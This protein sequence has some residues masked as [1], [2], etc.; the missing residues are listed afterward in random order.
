[1]DGRKEMLGIWLS[2]NESAS[3][4]TT[5]L[6]ELKNHGVEDIL[7]A[8]RDN[9]SGFSNAIETVFPHTEQQLCVIHQ[10]R[11]SMRYVSY[12]DLK[13]VM[14]DLKLIYGAP[15]LDETEYR[16]EEF[17]EKWGTRYPQILKSWDGNWSELSTYFRYPQ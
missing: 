11:N 17:R 3:F 2:E 10:I 4:W 8:C 14:S 5:V 16:S 9:L 6:N 1:M 15:T 12:K 7:I 13:E